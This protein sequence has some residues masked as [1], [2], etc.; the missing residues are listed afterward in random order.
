M[1]RRFAR[2]FLTTDYGLLTTHQEARGDHPARRDHRHDA[3]EGEQFASA[4]FTT[5]QKQT[6]ARAL[7]RFGVDA[8]EITNPA[9]SPRSFADAQLLSATPR[10]AMLLAHVR[11]TVEDV[12][13]AIDAGVD[14]VNIFYG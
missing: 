3:P 9:A 14:G 1:R 7:D 10:R 8:I 5:E 6:I 2:A 11:C 4:H 13:A 12:Q